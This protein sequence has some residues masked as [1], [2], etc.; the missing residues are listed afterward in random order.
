M[1]AETGQD[2]Q[3]L[4]AQLAEAQ[5]KLDRLV[6][7][8]RAIDGELEEL[9]TERRQ[10]ELVRNACVALDEL[11]EIGGAALFWGERSIPGAEQQQ[12]LR[13]RSL[14]EGF[15]KRIGEIE[16]RRHAVYEEVLQQQD[17]TDWIEGDVLEA[18]EEELKRQQEWI[19]EREMSELPIR[20][21]VMPWSRRSEEDYRFRKSLA[22]AMLITLLFA[23]VIPQIEIP[24]FEPEALPAVPERVVKLMTKPKPLPPRA[25]EPKPMVAAQKVQKPEK[26][27]PEPA[28]PKEGPGTGKAEGPG[29]GPAKGLLA[30][31]EQIS[32]IKVNQQIARLGAEAHVTNAG[33][34]SGA[35]ERSMI[36]TNAPGSSGGI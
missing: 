5:E 12:I 17:D 16:E 14:V 2:Q 20:A 31:R 4:R 7:D 19:V 13:A 29:V 11:S 30:F 10:H 26:T 23:L 24:I 8:L 3:A 34:A 32:G 9:A 27:V 22:T 1:D 25:P 21:M 33:A 6:R 28:K 15:E 35:V 36:S 18:E